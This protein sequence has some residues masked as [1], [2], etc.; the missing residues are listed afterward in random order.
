MDLETEKQARTWTRILTKKTHCY[1]V[2][3][4][5]LHARESL[6]AIQKIPGTVLSVVVP[7][8]AAVKLRVV[9]SAIDQ[10]VARRNVNGQPESADYRRN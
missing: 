8:Y 3:K 5:K 10:Q 4:I 9:V 6:Q 2:K 1:L 7:Q